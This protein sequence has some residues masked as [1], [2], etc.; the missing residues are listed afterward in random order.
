VKRFFRAP[1]L[2]VTMTTSPDLADVRVAP[3]DAAA[4][5]GELYHLHQGAIRAFA[6]RLVGDAAAA[7]D[8]VH[9]VFVAAAHAMQHYRGEAT[10]RTFLLSIAVHVA[11]KHVRAAARRRAAIERAGAEGRA[12]APTPEDSTQRR[13]LAEAL[14]G[15][16]DAL[17]IEQR[18]AFVLLEIEER[19]CDE[20]ARIADVPES[21][22]RTRLFHAKR[23]LREI[24]RK[25]GIA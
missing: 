16:L 6:R 22:M 12:P 8:L 1:M 18:V 20:A 4:G 5:M 9:D 7:E 23:R 17:P 2:G 13:E 10:V 14:H 24:L 11:R 15:A 19:S 25:R 3:R 21:T